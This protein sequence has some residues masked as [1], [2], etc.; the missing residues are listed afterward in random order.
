VSNP[1]K[2]R[3]K[4]SPLT[5][6]AIDW[7][8]LHDLQMDGSLTHAELARRYAR[9]P[10]VMTQRIARMEKAGII[11]GYHARVNPR[12]L[13]MP[14]TAIIRISVT[15]DRLKAITKTLKNRAEISEWYVGEGEGEAVTLII[16]VHL[17]FIERVEDIVDLL[18]GY[19]TPYATVVLSSP[20]DGREI[21]RP[22]GRGAGGS[23]DI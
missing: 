21:E 14:F 22:G 4:D 7:K 3:A 15:R 23:A 11:T 12:A 2:P 20:V 6:D 10:N 17:T 18:A 16:K 8:V 19:G 5:L 9:S 1:G 13:G